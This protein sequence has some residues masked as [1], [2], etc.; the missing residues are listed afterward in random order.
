MAHLLLLLLTTGLPAALAGTISSFYGCYTEGTSERALTGSGTVDAT[1]MT[2]AN[3]ETFC[4]RQGFSLYGLEYGSECYCGNSLSAGSFQSFATDCTS[5][6]A[7]S[8][9]ETCGG[10]RRLSLFGKSPVAPAISPIPYPGDRVHAYRPVGS[11]CYTEAV[12]GRALNGASISSSSMTICACADWCLN[13]GFMISGTEYGDECFCSNAIEK[14]ANETNIGEC[15][16]PCAGNRAEKCGGSD[17]LSLY[18]WY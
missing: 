12:G 1:S 10:S 9:A 14:S 18:E 17:R 13:N 11:G 16:F 6:C 4:Y 15:D 8:P 5:P 7:G 3:C 2:I